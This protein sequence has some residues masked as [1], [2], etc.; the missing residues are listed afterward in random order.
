MAVN[1]VIVS[2]SIFDLAGRGIAY[3]IVNLI[4]CRKES[5]R[6]LGDIEALEEVFLCEDRDV[7]VLGF[8]ADTIELEMLDRLSSYTRYFVVLSRHSAESGKPSLTTHTPGNPWNRSD[9]GG[10]PWEIPPSNPV[11]MWYIL[12][13]LRRYSNEYSLQGYDICYEVTHHGPTSISK[14]ITFIELGSS[15]KEWGD[16]RA[17]KV[18]ALASVS[19][20]E[21]TEHLQP[22]CIV[23]VGFGGTHYAPLFTRRAFEKNECYGHMVPN[24]VIKELALNELRYVTRKIIELTPGVR[25]VVIEKMRRELRNII[26]EE[27][28]A[29]NLEIARI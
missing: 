13:E 16:S 18:I 1:K 3:N 2:Y 11:L 24:Y 20:I 8:N 4:G 6:Y 17:Q 14:P 28:K 12:Q 5:P 15:E 23:T 27:T 9:V 25:R 26:E 21:K 19:A 22:S 10:K 29:W 7:L